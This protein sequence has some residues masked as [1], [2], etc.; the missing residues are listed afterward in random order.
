LLENAALVCTRGRGFP[1]QQLASCLKCPRCGSRYVTVRFF[2]LGSRRLNRQRSKVQD[3]AAAEQSTKTG[4]DQR[5]HCQ[6]K[7][8]AGV[9]GRPQFEERP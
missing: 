6:C 1:I 2:D 4:E 5:L 8:F 3:V 9:G 7:D